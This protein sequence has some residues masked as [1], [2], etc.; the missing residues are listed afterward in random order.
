VAS[1]TP[2]EQAMRSE[3]RRL[4]AQHGNLVEAR[5][6]S[7]LPNPRIELLFTDGHE[8]TITR[9]SGG[10]DI[11]MM[12]FGYSGTGTECFWA[13]L[14]EAGFKGVSLDQLQ[15]M[16]GPQVLRRGDPRGHPI[17][18]EEDTEVETPAPSHETTDL[19]LWQDVSRDASLLDPLVLQQLEKSMCVLVRDDT[20]PVAALVVRASPDEFRG[21]LT[22]ETEMSLYVHPFRAASFQLYGV[23]PTIWDDPKEP[24][25]KETWIVGAGTVTGPS[26]P[27]SE[28]QLSR[29]ESLLTQEYCYFL[30]VDHSNHVIAAR[31][32]PYT[33]A[34]QERF[35]GLLPGVR[36]ARSLTISN[37]EMIA[38]VAEYM[39]RVSLE[40]IREGARKLL[41]VETAPV[42]EQPMA[43]AATQRQAERTYPWR[44]RSVSSRVRGA[45]LALVWFL[46]SASAV[47][48]VV[49][50][51]DIEP[52]WLVSL[53]MLL[54]VLPVPATYML[55][56][57]RP[58][59]ISEVVV[60]PTR[61]VVFRRKSGEEKP[62]L[63][64][65]D[66]LQEPERGKRIVLQG[67]S[68]QGNRIR[69]EIHR[70]NLAEGDFDS[71]KQDLLRLAPETE[72]KVKVTTRRVVL[73][74][75]VA[76][77]CSI[78]ATC[79]LLGALF[80]GT[81]IMFDR[82]QGTVSLSL[83]LQTQIAITLGSFAAFV[84][85]AA[86]T[87]VVSDRRRRISAIWSIFLVLG[88]LGAGVILMGITGGGPGGSE[89]PLVAPV[90]TM[91]A[92][93]PAP[94]PGSPF[95]DRVV[96]YNPGQGQNQ[97][98]A[99]PETALGAPDLVEQP[100]CSGMLQLGANGS[101]LLVFV[102]N[103]ITDDR[104]PDFQVFGE[105]AR[106]DF[107]LVEVST[108]GLVW[109]SY[110]MTDECPEPFDLADVGLEQAVFVRITDVQPGTATGA[111]LDAVEALHSGSPLAGGVPQHLPDALARVDLTLT[112]EPEVAGAVVCQVPASS[113]LTIEGCNSEATWVQVTTSDGHEGWCSTTHL[114][115]NVSLADYGETHPPASSTPLPPAPAAAVTSVELGQALAE[116]LAQ[117]TIT[118][119]G[120]ERIDLVLESLSTEPLEITVQAGTIFLAQTGGTQNMVVRRSQTVELPSQGS[121]KTLTL[122]AACA[123]MELDAPGESDHFTVSP[124][125]VPED[126]IK[127]LNLPAF[128]EEPFR[129]QQFA[130]WTITDNPPRGGYVGLGY[131]GV[132]SGPSDEEMQ[133]IRALFQQAGIPTERYQALQ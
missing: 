1:Q 108:D 43:T 83:S 105:S 53:L 89:L 132:G 40:E 81:C 46:L 117:A 54:F 90:T 47:G 16:R 64:D 104:G 101:V 57:L 66:R 86:L 91:L 58:T 80:V 19:P 34:T 6:L 25:F 79:G 7:G 30:I 100:C 71:L 92:P 41:G 93:G 11:S 112:E 32:V 31:K 65:L 95:A 109:Q 61:G 56:A 94:T 115:L 82:L 17:V 119:Q 8:E 50:M 111:E 122:S 42:Q 44:G 35:L 118:G 130:I 2:Y 102:D 33:P 129:V 13:F 49:T 78:P 114:A 62:V 116:A 107:I 131:Y 120:L 29:L 37:T 67:R 88:L 121:S 52:N 36:G 99:D 10:A 123:S 27:L 63:A 14:D 9:H 77:L 75:V 74:R 18:Q 127:L 12:K 98:Y 55:H 97:Q 4:I 84:L 125:P 45:L 103:V 39:N 21:P 106:D 3:A 128:L 96:A 113:A 87:T 24:F 69:T 73:R 26:D 110:P 85:F 59:R 28:G 68:P 126:L 5:C 76:A 124:D 70:S 38:G 60:S 15:T 22:E 20:G 48:T 133:A 51:A 23:Y 72:A